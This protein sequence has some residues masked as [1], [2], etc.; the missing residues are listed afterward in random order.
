CGDKDLSRGRGIAMEK[1]VPGGEGWEIYR[2]SFPSG[3][4]S[5]KAMLLGSDGLPIFV[6]TES[7]GVAG[8]YKPAQLGVQDGDPAPLTRVGEWRA[9]QTG[10][11][12]PQGPVGEATVTGAAM[13]ADG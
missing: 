9:M 4:M 6:V 10:T 7:G 11:S 8:I 12:N 5:G 2:F 1:V 13:T 3:A